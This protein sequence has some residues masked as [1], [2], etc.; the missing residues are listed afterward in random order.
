MSLALL[1]LAVVYL[2]F[3]MLG[4]FFVYGRTSSFADAFVAAFAEVGLAIWIASKSERVALSGAQ[5]VEPE[6]T[7]ELH[8]L[9]DR[10]CALADLPKPRLALLESDTPNAY[11]TGRTT[12]HATVVV[13][14]GL[15]GRLEPAEI[16]AV[17]AHE[18]AHIANRDA[19]VMTLVSVPATVIGWF[20][21]PVV[22]LPAR[23]QSRSRAG[24]RPSSSSSC[25]GRC[26]S[27]SGL[28]G[29]SRARS[30]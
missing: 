14:R 8:E 24:W 3:F 23:L 22:S 17:V 5:I 10:L 18:L 15:L 4:V 28:S 16:E 21:R 11:S 2:P 7:P 13:S 25:S 9:V 27:P 19:Y 29:C 26:C 12:G 6:D 1:L 30:C 20:L